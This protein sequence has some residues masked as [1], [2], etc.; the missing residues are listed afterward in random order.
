MRLAHFSA[1]ITCGKTFFTRLSLVFLG[2]LG[3]LGVERFHS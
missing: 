3:V 2:A 1:S